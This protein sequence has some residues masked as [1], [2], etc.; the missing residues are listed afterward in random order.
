MYLVFLLAS[1]VST[2]T[3]GLLGGFLFAILPIEINMVSVFGAEVAAT[4][5]ITAATLA[6][7]T[8]CR[9]EARLG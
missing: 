4:T 2:P 5:L 9:K 1:T 7:V 8:G 3:I 6:L